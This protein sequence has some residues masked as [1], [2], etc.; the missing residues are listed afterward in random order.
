MA[1]TSSMPA[2][3]V[4][5]E[6]TFKSTVWTRVAGFGAKAARHGYSVD[7]SQRAEHE[8][9]LSFGTLLFS[10]RRI[11]ICPGADNDQGKSPELSELAAYTCPLEDLNAVV[12]AAAAV[13]VH[14]NRVNAVGEP[15]PRWALVNH[16]PPDVVTLPEG[17]LKGLYAD[18]VV[19]W[20]SR[21]EVDINSPMTEVQLEEAGKSS[22]KK[23]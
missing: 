1:K 21:P 4:A 3:K 11:A 8:N 17:E 20:D 10:I 23:G 9:H 13:L 5:S 18:P 14:A 2:I 19:L 12:A 22:S 15:L 7:I 16:K 6:H